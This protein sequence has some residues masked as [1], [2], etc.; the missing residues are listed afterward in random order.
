MFE[1]NDKYLVTAQIVC[2]VLCVAAAAGVFALGIL[3]AVKVHW[4]I[5]FAIPLGELFVWAIWIFLRAGLGFYCDVKLIR[6]KLYF[7][8]KADQANLNLLSFYFAAPKTKKDKILKSLSEGNSAA[9]AEQKPQSQTAAAQDLPNR[10]GE[11]KTDDK[12]ED[13]IKVD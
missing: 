3:Y 1:K 9:E 6:N 10:E 5:V 12:K 4:A 7:G 11:I 13:N 8:D 2:I